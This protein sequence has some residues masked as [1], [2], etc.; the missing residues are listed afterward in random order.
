MKST[1]D[2]TT[3]A[4]DIV[5]ALLGE[6]EPDPGQFLQ[7]FQDQG[8]YLGDLQYIREELG[9]FADKVVKITAQAMP[10]LIER[11][12]VTPTQS[13]IVAK[14]IAHELADR[15]YNPKLWHQQ[16]QSKARRIRNLVNSHLSWR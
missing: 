10:L 12:I 3:E 4:R 13:E 7:N 14:L 5:R 11:G 2:Q 8:N 1:S 9:R 15:E 6:A 16:W